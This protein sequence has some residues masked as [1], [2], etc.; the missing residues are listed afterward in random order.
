MSALAR[1]SRGGVAHV[2]LD[3]PHVR[4]ALDAA[5]IAE[6]RATFDE[7]ARDAS[8]RVIVL[9]GNGSAFCG[10]ADLAW[11]RASAELTYDE[12]VADATALATMFRAIDRCPKLVV[13]RVNGA[14]FGGGVGLAAAC[15]VV[16]AAD[17]AVFALSETKLGLVP[18]T[19]V[20]LVLAKIGPS[21]LRALALTGERFDARRAERIGLV[22]A[23]VAAEALDDAI[24]RVVR[25]AM[26]AAPGAIAAAKALFAD[27]AD[28][29]YDAALAPTA[30][31]I[32][33]R[34]ASPEGRAG[35]AAFLEKRP[36]PW[37]AGG[38]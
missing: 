26:L 36:P 38:S 3:R 31:A 22:H 30:S 2:A 18:A 37:S 8:V 14:A 1:A 13:G 33:A 15:D 11:M 5:L 28:L 9:S 29:S 21:H 17:D 27:V 24:D 32:A 7:L 19:I 34:R 6:L 12:N 23:V 25:E 10:G 16:V 4:N 20:P 35:V